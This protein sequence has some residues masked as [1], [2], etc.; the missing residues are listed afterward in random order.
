MDFVGYVPGAIILLRLRL[1]A[2]ANQGIATATAIGRNLTCQHIFHA[3]SQPAQA[4]VDEIGPLIASRTRYR[5]ELVIEP[6]D[7]LVLVVVNV[8]VV[9]AV[10]SDQ[11]AVA[12]VR[13][14]IAKRIGQ[15]V[16][17]VDDESR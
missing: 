17:A 8:L 9:R 4:V 12:I 10:G 5:T 13:I 7:E 15:L 1:S 3:H 11:I 6:L 14:G 2:S 16:F